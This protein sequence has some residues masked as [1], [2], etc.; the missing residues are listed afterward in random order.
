VKWRVE[1]GFELYELCTSSMLG[2]IG[3]RI[4]VFNLDWLGLSER[5]WQVAV[6]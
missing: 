5:R 3:Q 1:R 4:H 2:G 6:I